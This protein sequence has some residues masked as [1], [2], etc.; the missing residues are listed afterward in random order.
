[1]TEPLVVKV[2]TA[3]EQ[4]HYYSLVLFGG[5]TD[6]MLLPSTPLGAAYERSED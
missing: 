3:A 1:M 4:G 6:L 5:L 2:I